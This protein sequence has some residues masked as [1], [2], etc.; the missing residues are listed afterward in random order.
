MSREFWHGRRVLLTGH[1]GFKG[2]W[3]W[4]WLRELEAQVTGLALAPSSSPNLWDIVGGGGTSII[5]DVRDVDRVRD[6]VRRADPQV[7]FHLA[8]QALVRESYRDP[9][10]TFGT[11]VLGTGSLLQACREHPGLECIVV[12]TSDK[13]YENDGGGRAFCEEDRLGGH[14]PYSNSKACAE[15]LTACFRDSF[16]QNGPPLATARAGNVIG[17][18]DWSAER[19]IPDCVRA[20]NSGT[21]VTLRYPEAVRPWQHVLEP[22]GGY[23]ALAERL[24]RE[25]AGAPRAVNFGPDAASFLAVRQVVDGFS[26]RFGG[27]PGWRVDPSDHPAEARALTLSSA[28]AERALGWRPRLEIVDALAWTADWYRAHAAKENM[29]SYSRMQIARYE[30]LRDAP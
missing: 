15:L 18:G 16:F 17:G 6:A 5:S 26:A 3:L 14:D 10:G 30:S 22:L 4:L 23:L 21:T 1:T 25:P 28:L 19:L 12:V 13:V 27:K 9:L 29:V 24:V 20:L 11:N 2:G 8:A 7:V